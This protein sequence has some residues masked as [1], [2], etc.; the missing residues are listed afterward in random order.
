MRRLAEQDRV[1]GVD[2]SVDTG[3]NAVTEPDV[4]GDLVQLAIHCHGSLIQSGYT[5]PA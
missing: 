3:M 1:V 4:V 5:A 2:T